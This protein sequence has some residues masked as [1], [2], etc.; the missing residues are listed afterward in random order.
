M[1]IA[2]DGS[3]GNHDVLRDRFG[4]R[5]RQGFFSPYLFD[6]HR[7]RD[8]VRQI[9]D[10]GGALIAIAGRSRHGRGDRCRLHVR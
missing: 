6:L 3:P 1:I 4:S 8:H 10:R 9:P 2:G 7:R 5:R